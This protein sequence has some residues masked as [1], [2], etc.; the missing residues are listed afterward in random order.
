MEETFSL[1][2]F[3]Y[4][5]KVKKLTPAG[6]EKSAANETVRENY[7]NWPTVL[8]KPFLLNEACGEILEEA[9]LLLGFFENIQDLITG[10]I[11]YSVNGSLR[12]SF[13]WSNKNLKTPFATEY[14][15]GPQTRDPGRVA[16]QG[17]SFTTYAKVFRE[18]AIPRVLTIFEKIKDKKNDCRFFILDISGA[19]ASLQA[20]LLKEQN[21][22]LFK[23]F[24]NRLDLWQNFVDLSP[25]YAPLAMEDKP[26]MKTLF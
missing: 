8:K 25:A 20:S 24:K 18:K 7:A 5:K 21:P 6:N 4:E 23:I 3:F 12:R 19:H 9:A 22:I 13:F 15:E 10:N 14:K 16:I 26:M 1:L 2:L 17:M 11:G